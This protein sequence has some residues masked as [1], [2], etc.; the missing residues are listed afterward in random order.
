MLHLPTFQGLPDIYWRTS[1]AVI[2]YS[3]PR[4][5]RGASMNCGLWQFVSESYV[6]AQK[7]GQILG[8]RH[9]FSRDLLVDIQSSKTLYISMSPGSMPLRVRNIFLGWLVGGVLQTSLSATSHRR[10]SPCNVW[11][12][13]TNFRTTALTKKSRRLAVAWACLDG[14]VPLMAPLLVFAFVAWR[15]FYLHSISTATNRSVVPRS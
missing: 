6:H 8:G 3:L 2:I 12:S 1:H 13:F 10:Y 14:L 11:S 4:V 5:D 15:P 9:L 7:S